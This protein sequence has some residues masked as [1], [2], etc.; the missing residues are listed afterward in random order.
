MVPVDPDG[1]A[2]E[3]TAAFTANEATSA[4]RFNAAFGND[5]RRY[6][7]QYLRDVDDEAVEFDT[8]VEQVVTWE[9]MYRRSDPS[10]LRERI[11]IDLHH[12]QLPRLSE[13]GLIDRNS[14]SG[15][16]RYRGHD[17]IGK[18]LEHIAY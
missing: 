3:S 12:T 11:A 8:L 15:A 9:A 6:V 2:G 4:R 1:R 16:I 17:L 13:A 5:R 10:T 14:E 18:S 7:L